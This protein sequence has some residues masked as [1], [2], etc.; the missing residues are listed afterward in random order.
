MPL[1]V[2]AAAAYVGP[3]VLLANLETVIYAHVSAV[4]VGISKLSF[5][6]LEEC[7]KGELSEH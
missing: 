2:P 6:S 5:S 3:P 1:S 4:R 7:V